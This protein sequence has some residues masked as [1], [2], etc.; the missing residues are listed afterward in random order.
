MRTRIWNEITKTKHDIEYLSAYTLFQD[1]ISR[2]INVLILL[3]SSSG[4]LGWSVFESPLFTGIVCSITAGISLIKL[5]SPYFILSE[6]EVKKLDKYYALMIQH[7]DKIEKFWYDNEDG[8]IPQNKLTTEFYQLTEKVNE[9][10]DRYG[11][12]DIRHINRLSKKAKKNSDEYFN[13]NFNL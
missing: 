6:K 3:F 8:A 2:R 12:L 11:D 4:I 9:I 1:K 7:F 13:N 5:I 10:N